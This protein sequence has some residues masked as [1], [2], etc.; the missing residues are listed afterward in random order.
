[1]SYDEQTSLIRITK[2]RIKFDLTKIFLKNIRFNSENALNNA[3]A[4]NV[5]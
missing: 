1:M 4:L 2:V 3:L 5:P